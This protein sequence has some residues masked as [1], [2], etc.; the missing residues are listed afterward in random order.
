MTA[1]GS[2]SYKIKNDKGKVVTERRVRQEID[3]I[4]TTFNIQLDNPIAILSQ[5]TAKTL[6]FSCDPHKLYTFF[7]KS[8]QLDDCQWLYEEATVNETQ[9]RKLLKEKKKL[10]ALKKQE[11]DKTE[12][13]FQFYACLDETKREIE[14]LKKEHAI[15]L[16]NEAK[17]EYEGKLKKMEEIKS[18]VSGYKEKIEEA[19]SA[20]KNLK[21]ERRD[22]EHELEKTASVNQDLKK[23]LEEMRSEMRAARNDQ[24]KIEQLRQAKL[25]DLKSARADFEE[26]QKQR[27]TIQSQDDNERQTRQREEKIASLEKERDEQGASIFKSRKHF[28]FQFVLLQTL[29]TM[30]KGFTWEISKATWIT[31]NKITRTPK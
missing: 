26:N 2:G 17:E 23:E 10:I 6:L 12:K 31:R 19:T 3:R 8:T 15:A 24:K 5:D 25:Q 28:Q 13:K 11:L 29:N 16:R 18:K 21:L 9:A 30:L 7:M 27:A 22:L 1:S 14:K 4:M 20:Q